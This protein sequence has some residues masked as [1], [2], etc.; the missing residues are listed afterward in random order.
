MARIGAGRGARTAS[1]TNDYI[2]AALAAAA[3]YFHCAQRRVVLRHV[4]AGS[5]YRIYNASARPLA[6]S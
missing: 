1:S 6:R 4:N 5:G 2:Y 3:K